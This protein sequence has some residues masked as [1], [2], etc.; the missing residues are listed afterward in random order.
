VQRGQEGAL[1]QSALEV[2]EVRTSLKN[3][4]KH[5]NLRDELEKVLHKSVRLF[6]EQTEQYDDQIVAEAETQLRRDSL[7][8]FASVTAI[9]KD[10]IE[11]DCVK[12]LR[13]KVANLK[14]V[15]DFAKVL[16]D[17]RAAKKD[18]LTLFGDE[19]EKGTTDT[20]D[21]IAKQ[22][23]RFSQKAESIVVEAIT[24]RVNLLLKNLQNQKVKELDLKLTRIFTE[25]KP[26]FWADFL[27]L[28]R[29]TFDNYSSEILSLREDAAELK[30]AVDDQ[31]FDSM[32]LDLYL[33]VRSSLATRLRGLG[34]LVLEKFR[35]R[36][37]NSESGMRRN[38][39]VIEEAEITALFK[40]ARDESLAVLEA[41]Q[42]LVYPALLTGSRA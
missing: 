28:F 18:T 1:D 21:E 37:E 35:R 16:A 32:K 30:T 36:F 22:V 4:N 11:A 7:L 31:L 5:H 24:S 13:E 12:F 42:D 17:M 23:D 14:S 29:Q 2:D 10:R 38:W 33:T 25:L 8:Q 26:T 39:K 40:A 41:A 3:G 34:P 20:K 6:K 15:T 9:Q 27:E 19:L